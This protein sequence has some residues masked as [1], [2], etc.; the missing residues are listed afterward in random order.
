MFNATR[1]R[2]WIL[3]AIVVCVAFLPLIISADG[4]GGTDPPVGNPIQVE[5]PEPEGSSQELS[6]LEI[7]LLAMYTYLI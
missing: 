5:E 7:L 4:I 2:S 3:A 1:G 6:D